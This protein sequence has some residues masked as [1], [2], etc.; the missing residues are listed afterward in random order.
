MAGAKINKNRKN[1]VP[2]R[3]FTKRE[4]MIV[5][6]LVGVMVGIAFTFGNGPNREEQVRSTS[7]RLERLSDALYRFEDQMG[8]FPSKREG[9]EILLEPMKNGDVPLLGGDEMPLHDAWGREFNYQSPGDHRRDFDLW[10]AGSD[11]VE[12]NDDDICNWTKI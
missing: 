8:R 12:M 10:S 11:N 2:T 4:F 6:A 3:K 1:T 7:Q 9:L 5:T